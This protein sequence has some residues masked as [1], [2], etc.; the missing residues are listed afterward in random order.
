M[1]ESGGGGCYPFGLQYKHNW[2]VHEKSEQW[3]GSDPTGD[4]RARPTG[5]LHHLH[6]LYGK[7]ENG[8]QKEEEKDGGIQQ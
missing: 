2:L 7:G 8:G 1:K 4:Q 6:T 3:E 5:A